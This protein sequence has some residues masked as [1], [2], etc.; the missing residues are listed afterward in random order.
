MGS[1]GVA[2]ALKRSTSCTPTLGFLFDVDPVEWTNPR[3]VP[4]V[5]LISSIECAVCAIWRFKE[6]AWTAVASW[7][8]YDQSRGDGGKIAVWLRGLPLP[9]QRHYSRSKSSSCRMFLSGLKS[10]MD[11]CILGDFVL[12]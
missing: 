10:K 3:D 5:E 9:G 6:Y 12:G 11:S 1:V 2:V 7:L 4:T 8:G